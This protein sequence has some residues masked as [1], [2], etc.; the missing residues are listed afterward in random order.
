MNRISE[1]GKNRKW[2]PNQQ[3]YQINKHQENHCGCSGD[4]RGFLRLLETSP[5]VSNQC[6]HTVNA[7]TDI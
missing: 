2:I 7:F 1:D 4:P 5:T 6:V 3:A